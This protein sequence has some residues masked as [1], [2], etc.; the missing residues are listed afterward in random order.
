MSLLNKNRINL[1]TKRDPLTRNP[2]HQTIKNEHFN[3]L[4]KKF[5]FPTILKKVILFTIFQP[6]FFL[7]TVYLSTKIPFLGPLISYSL[8]AIQETGHYFEIVDLENKVVEEKTKIELLENENYQLKKNQEAIEKNH[9]QLFEENTQREKSNWKAITIVIGLTLSAFAVKYLLFG[10]SGSKT[11]FTGAVALVKQSETV[12]NERF[13][14]LLDRVKE[15]TSLCLEGL[16]EQ[17][18]TAKKVQIISS[19]MAALLSI[20]TD[21]EI[22]KQEEENIPTNFL[23]TPKNKLNLTFVDSKRPDN[24]SIPDLNSFEAN[25]QPRIQENNSSDSE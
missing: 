23:S 2:D 16:Q 3:S 18:E 19:A 20:H 17:E 14:K 21:I 9:P 12:N 15:T 24:T 25:D 6:I 4:L 5:S 11:A 10:A 1:R 13:E 7:T 8:N 22:P